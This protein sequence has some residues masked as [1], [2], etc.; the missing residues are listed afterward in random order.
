MR[1]LIL[2]S[3]SLYTKFTHNTI[4]ECVCSKSTKP[5]YI[6]HILKSNIK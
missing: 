4:I 2:I 5:L 3:D 6:D 1:T